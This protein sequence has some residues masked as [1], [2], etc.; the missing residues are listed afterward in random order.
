M[1]GNIIQKSQ[2]ISHARPVEYLR[3]LLSILFHW[4]RKSLLLALT[5]PHGIEEYLES[6]SI[7][8]GKLFMISKGNHKSMP[9]QVLMRVS[10]NITS[11]SSR[12]SSSKYI[13]FINNDKSYNFEI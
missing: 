12:E 3:I 13:K 10:N 7:P 11:H 6:L 1:L 2:S 5:L 9:A 4:A 8:R